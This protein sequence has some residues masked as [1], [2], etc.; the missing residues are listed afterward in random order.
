MA[1]QGN[2]EK[3]LKVV[4]PPT[5]ASFYLDGIYGFGNS[6]QNSPLR[7][8]FEG[9][10]LFASIVKCNGLIHRETELRESLL[11]L[12]GSNKQYVDILRSIKYFYF[13]YDTLHVI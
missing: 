2:L 13:I 11:Q 1:G 3:I 6:Y 9:R 8:V 5:C 12:M 4:S 10:R 7:K